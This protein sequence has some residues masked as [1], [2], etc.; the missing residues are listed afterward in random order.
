MPNG[1]KTPPVLVEKAKALY[2][3]FESY[4]EVAR[5]LNLPL[6]TVHDI[7]QRDDEFVEFRKEQ[8]RLMIEE[9]HQ[10][11][12][13]VLR[14]DIKPGTAKSMSEAAIT[15]GTLVDKM[16]V[17]AGETS[18]WANQTFNIGDN[19]KIVIEVTDSAKGMVKRK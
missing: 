2:P 14:Q 12:T 7:I 17:L 3:L 11:A 4:S 10:I 1:V 8:K 16:S 18:R 9:V 6:N 5:R 19:R 15:F 13:E